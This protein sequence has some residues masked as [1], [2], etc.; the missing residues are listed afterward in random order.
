MA[1]LVF[2]CP[3]GIAPV[4]LTYV[5]TGR[6]HLQL[7]NLSAVHS[8]QVNATA[9]RARCLWTVYVEQLTSSIAIN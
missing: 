5:N 2:K 8:T 4:H 9:T 6:S 1:F 3:H 7:A